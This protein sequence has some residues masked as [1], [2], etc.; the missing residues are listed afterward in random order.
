MSPPGRIEVGVRT[1]VVVGAACAPQL[2]VYSL[3]MR[4][5]LESLTGLVHQ[6][7]TLQYTDHS[8]E[9]I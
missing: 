5:H 6:T 8:E 3:S 9:Q 4:A 1:L 7:E 2:P